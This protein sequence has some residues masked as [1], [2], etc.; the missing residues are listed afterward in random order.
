MG[1]YCL[2]LCWFD[3]SFG[4]FADGFCLLS[5][6][7]LACAWCVVISGGFLMIC[8][9]LGVCCLDFRCA[10]DAE[11]YCYVLCCLRT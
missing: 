9:G 1:V 5:L 8:L 11:L 3:F 10:L 2:N 6:R 7:V 4:E